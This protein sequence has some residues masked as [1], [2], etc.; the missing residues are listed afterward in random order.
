MNQVHKHAKFMAGK[1]LNNKYGYE[2]GH[3]YKVLMLFS[4]SKIMESVH[5]RLQFDARLVNVKKYYLLN[6]FNK[7]EYP[8]FF[9]T[10]L[11]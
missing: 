2:I 8:D 5:Q 7:I 10:W 11:N 3:E 9:S 4:N 1:Q 6:D